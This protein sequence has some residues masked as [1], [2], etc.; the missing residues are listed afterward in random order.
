M[1]ERYGKNSR[2]GQ[3]AELVSLVVIIGWI[4]VYCGP[5]FF[6]SLTN[7]IREI[8][9]YNGDSQ[10][11]L[12]VVEQ[13]LA[14]VP[15]EVNFFDYGN[16]YFNVSVALSLIYSSF[17]HL[18]EWT[19]FFILRLVS[20]LGGGL[21]FALI[22]LWAKRFLG[23]LEAVFAACLFAFSPAAVELSVDVHPDS[24]QMFFLTLSL[25]LCARAFAP[26]VPSSVETV[27]YQQP[28]KFRLVLGAAVA[29]GAAFGTKYLGVLLLPVLGAAGLMIPIAMRTDRMVAREVR[30]IAWLAAIVGAMLAV[31]GYEIDLPFLLDL[32]PVWGLVDQRLFSPL[33]RLIQWGC[34][35][36][37]G[38]CAG[39]AIAYLMGFNSTF[40]RACLIR[41]GRLSAIALM[42]VF[43]FVVASP[44]SVY[45]LQFVPSVVIQSVRTGLG[46]LLGCNGFLFCSVHCKTTAISLAGKLVCLVWWARRGCYWLWSGA[47]SAAPGCRLCSRSAS[48]GSSQCLWFF[49]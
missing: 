4:A 35:V 34:F 6:R 20:F 45:G 49:T 10:L 41:A 9:T 29:A 22:F 21:T 12:S 36:V 37:S 28:A 13:T 48:S 39:G 47:T 17:W 1:R 40:Y 3:L 23:R 33:V 24:W 44:W 7:N 8:A 27:E 11:I 46:E 2:R 25:Y 38:I 14:S 43:G 16:F 32:F 42:F 15:F 19:T 26:T 5:F 30:S 18:D 31:A